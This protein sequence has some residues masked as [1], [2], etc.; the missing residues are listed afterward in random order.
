MVVVVGLGNP[1]KKYENTR[2]NLGFMV[3]DRIAARQGFTKWQSKYD[4]LYAEGRSGDNRVMLVK[5]QTFM[6]LSGNA[7]QPLMQFFKVPLENLVVVVDDLDLDLGK[8]RTRESGSDGGHRGLR[9]ITERLGSQGY[10]RI[11]VGIG[12]PEPGQSVI[13]RVLGGAR[14]QD[15]E[16]KLDE[17]M[18]VATDICEAFIA[19]GK[20]ENWSST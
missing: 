1:G 17:A 6:N 2:H 12:R 8:V 18:E 14:N 5:P 4:S 7:V 11:R 10:K 9:S 3:V 19:T 20:F 16:T 13:S 15:E